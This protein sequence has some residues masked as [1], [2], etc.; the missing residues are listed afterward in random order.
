[1]RARINRRTFLAAGAGMA[2]G[3]LIGGP[4]PA[5]AAAPAGQRP[6][7]HH[8]PDVLTGWLRAVYEQVR[9][10]RFSPPAAARAYAYVAIAA[11]EAV[12]GGMPKHRSL[13]GQLNDLGSLPIAAGHH[14]PVALNEAIVVTAQAVFAD[15]SEL[16]RAAL[17]DH[18]T[19]TAATIQAGITAPVVE[20]SVA[21]GRRIGQEIAGRAMRDNYLATRGLAYTPPVGPDKWIRTPPNFGAA[22][23]PHWGRIRSFALRSNDECKPPA[24]IPYSEEPGSPFW[25]QAEVVYN[26][27]AGLDDARRTTALF[28]RDNPDGTTGLP[29]GHWMLA[30]CAVIEQERLDLGRAAEVLA[31]LGIALADGFTSCWTEKYQTNLLRPVTYIQRLV[32]PGWNSFVNS[33]AFPEYTSGHSVGSAAAAETLTAL[34]GTVAYTDDTGLRNGYPGV[35]Y[36]SFWEAA[37]EAAM[38]RLHG[39]IHYPMG[40]EAGLVQGAEV[41]RKVLERIRTSR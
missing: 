14:W 40:I 7:S 38:S 4:S 6:T 37:N 24:P 27:S 36:Q 29:S 35:R 2:T 19:S 25:Q 31:L 12:V 33:P 16:S 34:L 8:A 30:A 5:L 3:L 1:M 17:A 23:E 15:R 18:A 28:W 11:Y 21:Y 13:G 20:R 10:E 32:D 22:I 26:T 41:A 9:I 39:G